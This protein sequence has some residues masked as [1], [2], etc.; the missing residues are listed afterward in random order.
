MVEKCS[1]AGLH[2]IMVQC[3]KCI[4]LLFHEEMSLKKD[5]Q[6]AL[7]LT[8]SEKQMVDI[9]THFVTSCTCFLSCLVSITTTILITHLFVI[10]ERKSHTSL[11]MHH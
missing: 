8:Q 6:Q 3:T 10:V 11:G 9:T 5:V 2:I 7:K 4:W 1:M